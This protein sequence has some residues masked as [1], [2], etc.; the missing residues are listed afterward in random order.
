M[1]AAGAAAEGAGVDMDVGPD[2]PRMGSAPAEWAYCMP[3]ALED[4]RV[5]GRGRGWGPDE[6]E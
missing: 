6:D 1:G 3:A 5:S 4:G 2:E